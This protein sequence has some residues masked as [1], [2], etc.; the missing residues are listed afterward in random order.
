MSILKFLSGPDPET[1]EKKGDELLKSGSWGPAKLEFERALAKAEK[2]GQLPRSREARLTEKIA[3]ASEEL[4]AAHQ[5]T[6]EDYMEN[7]Y[8]DEA[9]SYLSLAREI[10]SRE[11]RI[12]DLRLL[13]EKLETLR[14]TETENA[15]EEDVD[16]YYGLADD[17]APQEVHASDPEEEF[18]AICAVLP[19][20]IREIYLAYDEDFRTGYLAL[21]TAD[22]ETAATHLARAIASDPDPGSYIRLELATAYLHLGRLAEAR[23]LLLP[24]LAHHPDALPAYRLLCEI[25]WEEKD[26]Q[27]ADALIDAVPQPHANSLAVVLLR[28]ETRYHAGDFGAAKALYQTFMDGRGWEKDIALALAKAHEA[29]D[30]NEDARRIYRDIMGRSTSCRTR[31]DPTVKHKYAEL[32]FAAG[33]YDTHILELYLALAQELPHMAQDYYAR[34]SR[35]YTEQ[36]NE[37]EA[38]RFRIIARQAEE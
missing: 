23:E 21:N 2:K 5:K 22:F 31:I 4:A 13:E 26:F 34:V 37:T 33:I 20:E 36:G 16:E 12:Q 28:G 30:E 3:R 11:T 17:P 1:L 7:G 15:E 25:Y 14:Q 35:I 19:P 32:S 6:A 8:Y 24:F 38:A 29:A 9:G 27:Q 18:H 10:T